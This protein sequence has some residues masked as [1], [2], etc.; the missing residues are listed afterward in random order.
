MSFIWPGRA[1]NGLGLHPQVAP[2]ARD[3]VSFK[4]RKKIHEKPFLGV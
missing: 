1:H 3:T 2:A 4:A